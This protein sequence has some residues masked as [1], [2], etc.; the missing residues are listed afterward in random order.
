MVQ[1][2]VNEA[3]SLNNIH[4]FSSI[5]KSSKF[6]RKGF[7]R[8]IKI[9]AKFLKVSQFCLSKKGAFSAYYSCGEI[10]TIPAIA[11]KRFWRFKGP[12]S[13]GILWVDQQY[14]NAI[15]D[16]QKQT[17]SLKL[18]TEEPPML[19]KYKAFA[20][21]NPTQTQALSY[22]LIFI[23]FLFIFLLNFK[24][25]L[26]FKLYSFCAAFESNWSQQ[27]VLDQITERFL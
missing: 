13:T 18:M 1:R 26:F 22:Y 17:N 16:C 25:V 7:K 6:P 2:K 9:V 11:N 19:N 15:L 8:P 3:F 21:I 23:V 10:L 4:C 20:V 5:S 27:M 12:L 14:H 24:G